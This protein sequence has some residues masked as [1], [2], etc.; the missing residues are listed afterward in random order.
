[1][2]ACAELGVSAL[3][4]QEFIC[5]R[6]DT[7]ALVVTLGD[8]GSRETVTDRDIEGTRAEDESRNINVYHPDLRR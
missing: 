2:F 7:I 3:R 5:S 8:L 6:L 4:L 1:M